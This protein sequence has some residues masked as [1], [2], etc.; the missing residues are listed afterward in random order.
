MGAENDGG[1]CRAHSLSAGCI[2]V[3]AGAFCCERG[4]TI[5]PTKAKKANTPTMPKTTTKR[6]RQSR[7]LGGTRCDT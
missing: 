5:I 4:P 2:C 6:P 7:V 1:T 3:V